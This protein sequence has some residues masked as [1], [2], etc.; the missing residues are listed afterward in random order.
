[1]ESQSREA[2]QKNEAQKAK[3]DAEPTGEN[4]EIE[5]SEDMEG[6]IEPEASYQAKGTLVETLFYRREWRK[7]VK[8]IKIH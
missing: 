1:M 4:D 8:M 7:N 2:P 3:E 6:I 5:E